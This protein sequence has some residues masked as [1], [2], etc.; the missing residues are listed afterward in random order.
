MQIAICEDRAEDRVLVREYIQRYCRIYAYACNIVEYETAE[1]LLADYAPGHFHMLLL[2]IYLPG[3]SGMDAARKIR[4]CD[5][6]CA[7]V[8]LTIS[9][10]HALQGFEVRASHYIVKPVSP[11]RLEEAFYACR[12]AF[13]AAGRVI[14]VPVGNG[15]VQVP[16]PRIRYVEVLDKFAHFHLDSGVVAGRIALDEVEERLGGPP[17]LRCHR[18]YIVNMNYVEELEEQQF[19]MKS[20]AAVPIRKNGRR[21][22]RLAMARY[23][24]THARGGA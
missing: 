14:A 1:A 17:F 19:R 15:M 8:F 3:L 10:D 4:E 6:D 22:L 21:E 13:E 24:A 18:S 16:L 11:E 20:G 2:D 9:M 7:I 12:Q 5:L 23:L